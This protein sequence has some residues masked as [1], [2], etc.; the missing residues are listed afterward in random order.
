MLT[1]NLI[2][3][4]SAMT[5]GASLIALGTVSAAEAYS[6]TIP[7]PTAGT[8]L[9]MPFT[10][11]GNGEYQQV[12]NAAAFTGPITI[13]KLSFFDTQPVAAGG[14]PY[15]QAFA[16]GSAVISTA[17]YFIRLATTTKAVG[18]LDSSNLNNNFNVGDQTA[19]FNG[20][21]SGP[22]GTQFD[23]NK[24]QTSFTYNPSLGNLL[25]DVVVSSNLN[26]GTGYLDYGTNNVSD[27]FNRTPNGPTGTQNFGLVTGFNTTAVPEPSSPLLYTLVC[28]ALGVGYMLN[29]RLK[30]QKVFASSRQVN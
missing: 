23:I 14:T 29:R 1:S 25:F 7:T 21:L 12:Y 11:F 4:L 20:I 22:T 15:P 6:I 2:G 9:C 19:F 17:N 24:N 16:P 13:D 28:G 8:G 27:A 3:K 18:A 5:V 30:K 10:C 26:N